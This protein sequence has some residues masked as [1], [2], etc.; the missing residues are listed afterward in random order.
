MEQVSRKAQAERSYGQLV[1]LVH[2]HGLALRLGLRDVV[3][4]F[5]LFA[6][7]FRVVSVVVRDAAVL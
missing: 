4:L 2:E 5:E 1:Q 7:L 6:L 3:L